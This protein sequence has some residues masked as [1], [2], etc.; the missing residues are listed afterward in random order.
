M[1]YR[2]FSLTSQTTFHLFKVEIGVIRMRIRYQ[3][4]LASQNASSLSAVFDLT[5][6][7][8]NGRAECSIKSVD[9]VKNEHSI[10]LLL[11][12]HTVSTVVA[13]ALISF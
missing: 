1:R 4:P 9:G 10:G 6:N 3:N 2:W 13:T 7:G 5:F 8:M 11:G 12:T